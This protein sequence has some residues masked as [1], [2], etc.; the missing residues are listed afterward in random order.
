MKLYKLWFKEKDNDNKFY[1]RTLTF[2]GEPFVSIIPAFIEEEAGIF[3]EDKAN[4]Y[5]KMLKDEHKQKP[6]E[7]GKEEITDGN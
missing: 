2:G 5:I 7:F 4:A 1:V 6:L 3:E